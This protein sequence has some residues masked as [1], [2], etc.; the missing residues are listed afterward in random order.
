MTLIDSLQDLYTGKIKVHS[1]P[2]EKRWFLIKTVKRRER[3]TVINNT[4]TQK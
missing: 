4:R 2:R 3:D 1:Y